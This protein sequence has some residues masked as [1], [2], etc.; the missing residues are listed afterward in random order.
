MMFDKELFLS[1]CEKYD[2]ELSNAVTAP[3][4]KDGNRLHEITSDDINRI[5]SPHQAYFDYSSN[6]ITTKIE[7]P[8][9]YLQEDYAV[10]C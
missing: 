2:V 9:F 1:L 3:M 6:I 7:D 8:V 4:I 5:F 10:A